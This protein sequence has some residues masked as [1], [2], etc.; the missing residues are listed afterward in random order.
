MTRPIIA[1]A[2]LTAS[3][4]AQ[5]AFAQ[6]AEQVDR[7]RLLILFAPNEESK[8]LKLQYDAIQA[9]TA[10]VNSEDVDVIYVIG[11]RNVKLPPPEAKTVTSEYLRKRYHVDATAFRVVLIGRDGWEKARWSEPTD[12]HI[13]VGK[14]ADMPKP[15]SG[16][17]EQR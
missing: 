4:F 8:E 5:P 15:K 14:A 11:D 2:L 12:P 10:E 7:S 3:L 1:A 17:D 6:K 16:S 9:D 13:I